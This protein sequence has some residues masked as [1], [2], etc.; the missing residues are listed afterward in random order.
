M[1]EVW[2]WCFLDRDLEGECVWFKKLD[3]VGEWNNIEWGI[4]V[5]FENLL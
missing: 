5:F 3:N 1:V 2:K 4:N